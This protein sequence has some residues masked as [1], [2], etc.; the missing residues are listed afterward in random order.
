MENWYVNTTYQNG[1]KKRQKNLEM[2]TA[3]NNTHN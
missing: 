3:V 2:P 1:H